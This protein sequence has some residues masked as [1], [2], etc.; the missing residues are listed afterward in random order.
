MTELRSVDDDSS[1]RSQSSEARCDGVFRWNE[2]K[3]SVFRWMDDV[4]SYLYIYISI[5][6]GTGKVTRVISI[7]APGDFS[8]IAF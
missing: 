8:K 5:Y 3:N 1:V 2:S 4:V 7:L 6:P